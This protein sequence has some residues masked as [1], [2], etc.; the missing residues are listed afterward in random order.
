VALRRDSYEEAAAL[1]DRALQRNPNLPDAWNILGVA[2][3]SDGK[4]GAL[5]AWA[6]SAEL[7]PSQ[8][9]ALRNIWLVAPELGR[10]DLEKWALE[11]FIES[12]PRERYETDIEE[13]RERL[14]RLQAG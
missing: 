7:D 5:E 9:D 10:P 2:L 12:A 3:Y 6:R 11:R 8:Y 13:A 1:V 4:E 14:R